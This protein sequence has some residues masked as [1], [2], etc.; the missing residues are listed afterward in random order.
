MPSPPDTRP[1]GDRILELRTQR[2]WTKLD[3]ADAAGVSISTIYDI[4]NHKHPN[5][6]V[7][8]INKLVTAMGVKPGTFHI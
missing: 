2:G 3:L 1:I 5:P 6:G 7:L 4:E 8:T